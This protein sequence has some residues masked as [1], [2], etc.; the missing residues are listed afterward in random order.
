MTGLIFVLIVAGL[1]ALAFTLTSRCRFCWAIVAAVCLGGA[2]L[3]VRT[4]EAAP[5]GASAG[6][7]LGLGRIASG[8]ACAEF[9]AS[10]GPISGKADLGF[11]SPG[12][13]SR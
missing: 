10:G 4:L 9:F 2:A 11:L 8:Q 12:A 7:E 1:Y 6:T 5:R 13:T 3:A